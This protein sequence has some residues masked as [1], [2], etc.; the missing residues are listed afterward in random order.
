LKKSKTKDEIKKRH[1]NIG[2]EIDQIKGQI[3][4]IKNLLVNDGQNAQI[5]N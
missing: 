1:K 2:A 5:Q 4:E 3:K